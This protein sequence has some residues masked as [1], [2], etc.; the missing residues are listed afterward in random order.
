MLNSF[1]RSGKAG[2]LVG[3]ISIASLMLALTAQA[4]G[5]KGSSATQRESS[6]QSSGQSAGQSSS[7]ESATSSGAKSSGATSTETSKSSSGKMSRAD[8]RLMMQLAQAN[9]AEINA[10]KLAEQK[11]NNDQVKSFAKKMV[12]DHTKALDDLKQIASSKGVTLPTE[13][14]RQQMAMENKLSALSGEKFDAQYVDQS[15]SRAH[16]D[17][18]RLLQRASSRATDPDLK[19]YATQVMAT[20][21][22]HQQLARDTSKNL[23]STSEGKSGGSMESGSGSSR[24]K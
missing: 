15:G 12:D 6:G 23:Q 22:S 20:V 9:I 4:E 13:P 7:G 19:S 14:D 8:E 10:G 5:S 17:T 24:N 11:S 21:E 1:S 18:H 3:M 16:R 2:V